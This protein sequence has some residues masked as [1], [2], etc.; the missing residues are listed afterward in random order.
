[1]TADENTGDGY[2]TSRL[3]SWTQVNI[4][5]LITNDIRYLETTYSPSPSVVA[6]N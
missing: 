3:Q 5:F 1:M 6:I 2:P 4:L